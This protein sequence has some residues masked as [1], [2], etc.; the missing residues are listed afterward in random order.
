MQAQRANA[1]HVQQNTT[2]SEVPHAGH[3][4]AVN[5]AVG[6]TVKKPHL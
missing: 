2:F 6:F 1:E 3:I 4:Y 5:F